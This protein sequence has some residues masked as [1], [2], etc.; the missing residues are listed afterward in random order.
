MKVSATGTPVR[1]ENSR[2]APHAIPRT[3]PLP[4][5]TTGRSAEESSVAARSR[6]PS[7]GR[8]WTTDVRRSGEADTGADITSSGS[9]RWVGPGF[10]DSA[11]LNALRT[12]SGMIPGPVTRAFHFVIGLMSLTTSMYWCDSLCI[13]SSPLCPVRATSGARSKNA[14]AMPVTRFVAPGP[15]VPRHTPA[16]P[17][18]RPCTSAMNAA[19]CSWRTGTNS[20][21]EPSSASET[22]SVSSP[23]IPKIQRTPSASR[24]RTRRS[25]ARTGGGRSGDAVSSACPATSPPFAPSRRPWRR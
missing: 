19:A 5:S 8:G 12:A 21:D 25:A 1:A 13:R 18:S 15:R 22:S 2:S 3:T 23:G 16:R 6:S 9:S 20:I 24:H 14:S 11:T 7:V 17:V 4:A 10:S